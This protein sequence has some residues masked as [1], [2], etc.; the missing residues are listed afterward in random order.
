[1]QENTLHVQSCDTLFLLMSS[2]PFSSGAPTLLS[3]AQVSDLPSLSVHTK[4]ILVPRS[5]SLHKTMKGQEDLPYHSWSLRRFRHCRFIGFLQI[6][7]N[8]AKIAVQHRGRQRSGEV[9]RRIK[10][11]KSRT[12]E[13]VPRRLSPVNA[14]AGS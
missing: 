13:L 14:R 4:Y 5:G 12:H 9:F 11:L 3:S 8:T 7:F 6:S 1:M 10:Y 2:L